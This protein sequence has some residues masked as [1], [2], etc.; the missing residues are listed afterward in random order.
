[1]DAVHH[2]Q[3]ALSPGVLPSGSARSEGAPPTS[4]SSPGA[5]A[6]PEVRA[7]DARD[8]RPIVELIRR[9]PQLDEN[10]PYAYLLLCHHFGDTGVVWWERDRL[11]AF[12]LGYRPP[13]RP[14]TYFL[15]QVGVDP[16]CRGQGLARRSV[17]ALL[18]RLHPQGV[19][20]LEAT[21]TP[22]NEASAALFRGV[23]RRLGVPCEER[24][25]FARELFPA[26]DDHEE[27]VLF[28]I[29]PWSAI[30][31]DDNNREEPR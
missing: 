15:W 5:D 29:G 3:T 10:S 16:D 21:V 11:R 25:L 7:P 17:L 30:P 26:G 4:G 20:F 12:V 2:A 19:R 14:D 27:E 1:M 6:R 31:D 8:A 13:G 23:A 18:R 28:R 9:V 22:S 24:T